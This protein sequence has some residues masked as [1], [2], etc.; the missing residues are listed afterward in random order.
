MN[1]ALLRL[2]PIVARPGRLFASVLGVAVGVA[3][4]IATV[5]GSDAAVA[6]LARDV[7]ELAGPAVLEVRGPGGVPFDR[8]VAL[9][10]VADT[11]DLA[12]VVEDTA[13]VAP[14]TQDPSAE[15]GVRLRV[16]GLDLVSDRRL[17]AEKTGG[18]TELTDVFEGD[19]ADGDLRTLLFERGVFVPRPL[20]DELGLERGDAL[21][22]L[23]TG[24]PTALPIVAVFDP[25]R[26]ASPWA[27]TV[28][29]DTGTARELFGRG[30]R[31][32]RVELV[33]RGP[34]PMDGATI[35]ALR[36]RVDSLLAV[37]DARAR[38]W[39]DAPSAR[40]A[41]G[42]RLVSSL[43]FNLTA[44]SGVSM[45][46]GIALVATT[47]ATSV[48]QR[49]D[50]LALMR[51]LGA[52]RAQLAAGVLGEAAIIGLAGGVLGV[53]FGAFGARAA[54]VGVQGAAYSIAPDALGSSATFQ[55]W[56]LPFGVVLGVGAALFAALLPLREAIGVPPVQGLRAER[57][58]RMGP[59]G[60]LA[61]WGAV[62]GLV[63]V[64]IGLLQLPPI[65]RKP[66]WALT[67]CLLLLAASV[68]CTPSLVDLV[69]RARVGR[70][71]RG[72]ALRLAQA[73]L[74]SSRG[75]AAWA[76]GA[77][78]IAVGLAVAMATM[79]G[80]F[81]LTVVEWTDEA[82][83]ADLFVSSGAGET[84]DENVVATATELFG[85]NN[86]SSYRQADARYAGERVLLGGS[87]FVV[88]T[89]HGDTPLLAG[90]PAAAAFERALAVGGVLVNEPFARRFD[91]WVD[92]TIELETAGGLLRAPVVAV[93]REYAG[94]E[95][96]VLVDE[97][98]WLELHDGGLSRTVS[99]H[100][101][102]DADI[103]AD[104]TRFLAALGNDAWVD[105]FVRRELFDRVLGIFDRTFAVT[106]ALQVLASIAA[107]LAVVTV[108]GALVRER[109]FDLAVVRVIGAARSQVATL[110]LGEALVLGLVG[111]AAGTVLGVAVG[112]IL[113]TVVNV[114]SH[115][116]SLAFL[117]PWK[118]VLV[119]VA[120]V[121]P[122]CV[123]AGL[124]P[125]LGALLRPPRE[126]L[127]EVG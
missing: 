100:L 38:L 97:A 10:A 50:R 2:R 71:P 28:V 70:G 72:V 79:V 26:L 24:G 87:P 109:R 122:A 90:G 83:T 18:A 82:M 11:V 74:A 92:S 86:V 91:V 85:A 78:A 31:F 93:V 125:A 75:R 3:A 98:R 20:A 1:H 94:Q 67:A 114:Q 22:L 13:R 51:S 65:G 33:P 16:L 15:A 61:C 7:E 42:E 40:R 121:L 4:V 8:L 41:E 113:V 39:A 21:S 60:H 35:A 106:I 57:P 101:P 27:R 6:S 48:V 68:A 119:T 44:L 66:V 89:R 23:A 76:A 12:P 105:V 104:R 43:R 55:T 88:H 77:V 127:R 45:L 49:R 103:E 47:L 56:W 54:V 9:A 29:V 95:G 30:E 126:V 115:G 63:L 84:L 46:V 32:D 73:A 69:A 118:P 110:V 14:S 117:P 59:R 107:A 116:W 25:G 5:A 17:R 52:S 124:P 81:R 99:I 102:P 36:E 120:A 108:L 62:G 123:L 53:V 64:A 96:R 34:Q 111:A 19:G 112:W 58:S 37:D 80:S